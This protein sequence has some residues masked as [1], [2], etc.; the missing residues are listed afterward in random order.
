[1]SAPY[2]R[3]AVSSRTLP[4]TNDPSV[5]G[6][7]ACGLDPERVDELLDAT[8]AALSGTSAC[9]SQVAL[10]RNGDLAAFAT[11]GEAFFMGQLR[12]ADAHSLFCVY[13]V[14]KVITSAASWILLQEGALQLKD[15]AADHIPGFAANGKG[16]I[17]VEHL[18]T[19][20]AGIPSAQ[21]DPL[22]WP[23]AEARLERI[24]AWPLEWEPGSRFA[25]HDS[26]SMWVLR[27]IIERITGCELGAFVSERISRPLGLTDLYLGLPSPE[28]ARKAEVVCT[29]APPSDEQRERLGIH[30]PAFPEHMLPYHNDPA[31]IAL[32]W[33]SGGVIATA[34]AI[35]RVLQGFIADLEDRGSGIWT[36]EFLRNA[37]TPRNPDFIDSM[38]GQ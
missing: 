23:D 27:E 10:A 13:S 24:A 3:R 36:A 35:A 22:D 14:T 37:F 33:P 9:A 31:R 20:Q 11:F 29:G 6:P 32:G 17:R 1:M 15:R 8:A 26:S 34:A 38:T 18:L 16:G 28:M 5:A 7:E 21:L 12:P 2:Y 30:V 4:S 19:H 25:Y